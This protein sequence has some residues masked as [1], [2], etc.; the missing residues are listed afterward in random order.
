MPDASEALRRRPP[1]AALLVLVFLASISGPLRLAEAALPTGFHQ[2]QS[3]QPLTGLVGT[4][5]TDVVFSGRFLWVATERGL[6]RLDPA[7]GS[8][9]VQDDW[10]TFTEANGLG[11]GSVSAL[12]A[13]GDTVWAATLFDSL[14]TG[15]DRPHPVGSGLA[16]SVDGGLSWD[17]IT[18]E[19]LFDT[20]RPGFEGGPFTPVQNPCFGLTL[21]GDTIWAAFW[22]GSTVRST[23]FGRTWERVL[24]GGGDRIVFGVADVETDLGILQFEAD[25][26]VTAGADATQIAQI[27]AAIDSVAALSLLHRTFSVTAWGDT[28]W[29]GTASGVVS[30]FDSGST[31]RTH[32]VRL[33]DFDE[34]LPGNLSGN[35]G[36][37]IERELTADGRSLVWVGAGVTE[38]PGQVGAMNVT[39]DGI[40]WQATGPTFAWDFAFTG[41]DTIW[42]GSDAGLLMTPDRGDNWFLAEVEDLVSRDILLPTFVGVERFALPDGSMA[43]W[44]GAE[45]GLGRSI[46]GGRTWTILS[47]PLMTRSLD[48]GEF[49]GAGDFRDLDGVR[50]YAAPSPFAPSQGQLC[51]FVYSLAD[52]ARVTIEIYDFASRKVRTLVDGVDR[53]GGNRGENWDGLDDEGRAV[54][55]G[56]YFFRVETDGGDRAFGNLVVLD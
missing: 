25:S 42:A 3:S 51:R 38:G 11:R 1:A 15:L 49:I 14:A 6:A 29:I 37:A 43:L 18:N 35:W 22:S 20:L 16:W 19:A 5:I 10:L 41:G 56:V 30:S 53:G 12:A 13:S 48:S 2:D 21:D 52:D 34:P 27:R 32:K 7:T 40:T 39:E 28:V 46:D 8:G 23:D 45:N 26:L 33:N 44:A 24:P 54:A 47:F 50:A 55:N 9:L 17:H 4:S 31:W 36:L